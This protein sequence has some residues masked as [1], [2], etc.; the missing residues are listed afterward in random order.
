MAD[1]ETRRAL[2]QIF[3][4]LGLIDGRLEAGARRHDEFSR[5][6]SAIDGKVDGFGDR[7]GKVEANAAR[8]PVIEKAV[9]NLEGKR[10]EVQGATKLVGG[11]LK[12]RHVIWLTVVAVLAAFGIHLTGLP[13]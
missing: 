3:D 8:I 10:L 9:W 2:N 13:K 6:L 7:I 5:N 4:R 12:V 11:I 1:A